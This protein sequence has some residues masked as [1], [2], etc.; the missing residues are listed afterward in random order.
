MSEYMSKNDS[1]L[2]QEQAMNFLDGVRGNSD[3]QANI[4][5]EDDDRQYGGFF[6][7]GQSALRA[8]GMHLPKTNEYSDTPNDSSE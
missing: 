2:T 1:P 3:W 7:G 8:A 5:I 4:G 6:Q